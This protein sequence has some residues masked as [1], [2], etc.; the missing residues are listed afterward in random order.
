M[1]PLLI[2]P[3]MCA[4]HIWRKQAGLFQHCSR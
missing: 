3:V 4:H 2:R 1:P